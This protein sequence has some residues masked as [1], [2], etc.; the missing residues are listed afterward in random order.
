MH[1]CPYC[2][3]AYPGG[4]G[5]MPAWYVAMIPRRKPIQACEACCTFRC[6]RQRPVRRSSDT[7]AVH[8]SAYAINAVPSAGF[9][10]SNP[11]FLL[12]RHAAGIGIAV[13]SKGE[14]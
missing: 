14:R 3:P 13:T 5:E 4:S 10:L 9:W 6:S 12:N 8:T 1:V 7:A 11:C 2:S